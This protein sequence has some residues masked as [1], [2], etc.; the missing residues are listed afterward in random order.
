MSRLVLVSLQ[1]DAPPLGLAYIASY[2]K[3]YGGFTDI[4]IITNSW[5]EKVS[6]IFNKIRRSS[7]DIVGIGC[8]SPEF[9][10]ATLL[11]Q[12]IKS[13]IEIP[14]LIGGVHISSL[15]HLLPESFSVGILGEGEQTMLELMSVF[16]KEGFSTSNL[17]KI[18]GARASVA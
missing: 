3:E 17:A 4:K 18:K 2:L 8:I 1:N 14:V 10:K 9:N 5:N 15:P 16:E 6:K 13:E 11:S 7:P 12:K